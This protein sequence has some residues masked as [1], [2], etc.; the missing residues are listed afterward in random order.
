M[1]RI[2]RRHDVQAWARSF[3]AALHD[4]SGHVPTPDPA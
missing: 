3:L 4:G 2:V 1:R